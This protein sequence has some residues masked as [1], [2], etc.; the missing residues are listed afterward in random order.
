MGANPLPYIIIF[1]ILFIIALI[2]LTWA[3]SVYNKVQGCYTNP[4]IWCNDNWQCTTPC[5]KEGV[6]ACFNNVTTE[7]LA[8]CLYGPK[9]EGPT[10]CLNT[11]P[12][13]DPTATSCTCPTE[14][15]AGVPN[16]FAGCTAPSNGVIG[17]LPPGSTQCCCCGEGC[18]PCGEGVCGAAQTQS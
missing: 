16:C 18:P 11:P 8:S 6:S 1:A 7:G 13:S 4:N 2:A 10:I 15:M 9:A 3:L 17:N 12:G 14:L 5:T